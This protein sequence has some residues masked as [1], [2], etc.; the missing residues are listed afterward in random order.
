MEVTALNYTALLFLLFGF[1]LFASILLAIDVGR[2]FGI[3]LRKRNSAPQDD[4]MGAID[5][6]IFGLMGLL[7][8]FTFSGAVSRF[9][10]RRASI[11]QEANDIGTAYLRTKLLPPEYQPGIQE[12]FRRYVEARIAAYEKLPDLKAAT[13]EL[14][15]AD[16]LQTEIWADAIAGCM[17]T[18]DPAVKSLVLGSLNDMFD[19]AQTR[20]EQSRMHPP[21]VVPGMLIALVLICALLAGNLMAV[22]E[23]R[24]WLHI[25]LF[26]TI[27]TITVLVVLD[28]EYPRIG[29][30]R[31]NDW[32]RV[33]I[34]LRAT[35]T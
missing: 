31:I 7:I 11:V 1:G 27:L 21:T 9:D 19:M 10:A 28:I 26:S 5:G 6:A 22:N 18:R 2:R 15:R 34:E 23:T 25:L 13:A 12:E 14:Q 3:R 35:M 24:N 29:A 33:L 32:D 17:A 8:A 20:T 30:I 16:A 4:S